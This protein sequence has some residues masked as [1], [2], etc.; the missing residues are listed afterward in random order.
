MDRPGIPLPPPPT[1]SGLEQSG[2]PEQMTV[3]RDSAYP[4][5][6]EWAA[7]NLASQDLRMHAEILTALLTA[8][9]Q[10]SAPTVRAACIH[11]LARQRVNGEAFLTCLN[12]LKKDSDPRVR[13]EVDQALALVGGGSPQGLQ[14]VDNR[15]PPPSGNQ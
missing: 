4:A 2:I 10:D 5:Q 8:A 6:R 7:M 12:A 1:D 9:R 3:L 13:L 15:Q 11:G 14:P